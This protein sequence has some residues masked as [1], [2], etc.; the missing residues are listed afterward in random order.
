[1]RSRL[2]SLAIISLLAWPS[3]YPTAAQS[4]GQKS[5]HAFLAPAKGAKQTVTFSAD[6]PIIYVF[7]EGKGIDVGDTIGAIWIAEDIG[8]GSRKDTEIRRG[9]FRT[10]K[11]EQV[12]AFSL[13]RP[14]DK[15]WPIGKY[16]VE[17]YINGAIAE[18]VKFTITPGV[19]IQTH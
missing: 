5:L 1:M 11:Q 14:S 13:S 12:G 3:S 2:V 10:Y 7:W 16:R 8:G 9:D 18:I 6:A 15:D 19:T 4:S 17:L